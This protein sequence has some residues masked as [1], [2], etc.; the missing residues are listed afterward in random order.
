MNNQTVFSEAV[1]SSLVILFAGVAV[2]YLLFF[3]LKQLI[4]RYKANVIRLINKHVH[5]SGLLIFITIISNIVLQKFKA[6][7]LPLLFERFDHLM[8]ILLIISIGYFIMKVVEFIKDFI[9]YYYERRE[10]SDYSFRSAKTKYHLLQRIASVVIIIGILIAILTTFPQIRKIGGALVASA[11]V[12]GIVLGFA[13][14]KS[15]G[16][17]FA[18]IQIA[19]SQPIKIDDT[20][21]VENTFGTV[22]EITLTYVVINT[23]DEKRLIVPVNYFIEKPF[24][25]WTRNSPEVIGEVRVHA[26]Y[27]LPINVVRS[28]FNG[29]I[30]QSTLW[31]RRKSALLISDADDKT[32][33]VRATMSAKNSDDAFNLECDIRE[34]LVTFIQ[35]NYPHTLPSARIKNI[36]L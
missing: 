21:V 20:I 3:T 4:K 2:Y 15:L 26:D 22:G 30:E 29:W 25:N 28:A 9:L 11:G 17:L 12:A 6:F 16:S 1:T 33:E 14:Q 13:A 8:E 5:L 32:I 7:I 36:S 31:D 19:I 35:E 24:E 18:G 10:K 34:K 23:W 27:T